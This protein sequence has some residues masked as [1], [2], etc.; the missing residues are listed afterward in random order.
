MLAARELVRKKFAAEKQLIRAQP[1]L[2]TTD[3]ERRL[4]RPELE[5]DIKSEL[6]ALVS[7]AYFKKLLDS[8][9]E[10][11][12]SGTRSRAFAGMHLH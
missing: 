1:G 9:E 2:T 4:N 8:D 10:K 11:G 3:A 12:L 5:V 7:E 6:D